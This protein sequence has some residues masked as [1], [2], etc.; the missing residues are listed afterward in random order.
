MTMKKPKEIMRRQR[1]AQAVVAVPVD[2]YWLPSKR[3]RRHNPWN[4]REPALL[5]RCPG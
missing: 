5:I 4:T 3:P 2:E 1:F